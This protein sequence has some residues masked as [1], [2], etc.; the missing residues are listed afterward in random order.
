MPILMK[1]GIAHNIVKEDGKPEILVLDIHCK[2]TEAKAVLSSFPL[3]LMISNIK[4]TT[5]GYRVTIF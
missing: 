1:N 3:D 5:E 2:K 4:P